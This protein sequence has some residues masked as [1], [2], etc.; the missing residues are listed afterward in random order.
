MEVLR[1]EQTSFLNHVRLRLFVTMTG[2]VAEVL[3]APPAPPLAS[4]LKGL[5]GD[6]GPQLGLSREERLTLCSTILLHGEGPV[7]DLTAEEA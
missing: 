3:A 4:T 7:P 6:A 1:Q 2:V 5:D